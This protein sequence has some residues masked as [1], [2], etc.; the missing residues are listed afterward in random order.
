MFVEQASIQVFIYSEGYPVINL[1]KHCGYT[2]NTDYANLI[3]CGT[4]IVDAIKSCQQKKKSVQISLGGGSGSYAL[5][6]DDS[7]VILVAQRIWDLFLGGKKDA[8][9]RPFGE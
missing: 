5:P 3:K 7:G 2:P 8:N 6:T 9:L 4:N 1:S